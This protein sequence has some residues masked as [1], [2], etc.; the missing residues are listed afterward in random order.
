MNDKDIFK[1]KVVLHYLEKKRAGVD[2]T[3]IRQELMDKNLDEF[4]TSLI[5][6][7]I[8]EIILKEDVEKENNLLQ[9]SKIFVGW[10]L[11]IGGGILTVGTYFQ[12]FP[13]LKGF[14]ILT[15]GPIIGGYFIIRSAKLSEKRQNTGQITF[16]RRFSR[17]Q[18][19]DFNDLNFP[20]S[21]G[22][23]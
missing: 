19:S 17:S 10:L 5:I 11:L 1:E 6:R 23:F 8:D 3:S 9:V 21:F 18:I 20:Q 12:L 14:Y 7:I 22:P 4:N 13:F 16:S 2:Y 15:Y